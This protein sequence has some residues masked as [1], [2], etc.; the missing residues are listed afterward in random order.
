MSVQT[1]DE[2]DLL[3][4]RLVRYMVLSNLDKIDV[5]KRISNLVKDTKY[6]RL[7]EISEVINTITDVFHDE[8]CKIS[9]II[10]NFLPDAEC[11]VEE[12]EIYLSV[13]LM[14]CHHS[15]Y[16]GFVLV[17]AFLR[18]VTY[19]SY[20]DCKCFKIFY[21]CEFCFYVLYRRRFW[22]GLN[23]REDHMKL[24]YVCDTLSEHSTQNP[25]CIRDTAFGFYCVNRFKSSVDLFRGCV[26]LKESEKE[27]FENFYSLQ[28]YLECKTPRSREMEECINI[29]MKEENHSIHK[30]PCNSK[31]YNYLGYIC[32]F[33]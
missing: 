2:I 1:L 32:Q 21:I 13:C 20:K 3:Y 11:E 5:P 29:C 18:H 19:T 24:M 26:L 28:S 8:F 30:I 25:S 23:S 9:G 10:D 27:V 22:V 15:T 7:L 12:A 16:Y 33:L 14:L 31:C 17:A 6:R 4:S